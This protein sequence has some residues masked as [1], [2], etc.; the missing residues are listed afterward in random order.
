MFRHVRKA[1]AALENRPAPPYI[2][3]FKRFSNGSMS[4]PASPMPP[5]R[6][7]IHFSGRVQGVGFRYTTRNIASR[8]AVTGFVQNL[9]DGRVL[10][11]VEGAGHEIDGLLGDLR[12]EM[13]NYIRGEQA[14]TSAATGEF[15]DFAIRH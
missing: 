3:S 10:L 11:V 1:L 2:E 13:R 14:T 7:E 5:Q 4:V 15:N 9:H 6:R 12:A 8:Y